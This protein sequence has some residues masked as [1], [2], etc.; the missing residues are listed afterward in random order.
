MTAEWKHRGVD[1]VWT[2]LKSLCGFTQVLF[3]GL[4][5][6]VAPLPTISGHYSHA[7]S[8]M[9][10][11]GISEKIVY[12]HHFVNREL[13]VMWRTRKDDRN[14]K[15]YESVSKR[16]YVNEEKRWWSSNLQSV[17]L[18]IRTNLQI[19]SKLGVTRS[20][21]YVKTVIYFKWDSAWE[22]FTLMVC[23]WALFWGI[24]LFCKTFLSFCSTCLGPKWGL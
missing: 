17:V 13:P 11:T 6:E 9:W 7:S 5:L 22:E 8:W 21:D 12:S 15:E 14:T 2:A 20:T 3:P 18:L 24:L 10:Q 1:A 4:F 16:L 23:V 19:Y